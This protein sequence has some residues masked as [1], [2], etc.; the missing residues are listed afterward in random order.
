[1][2]NLEET[3][4]LTEFYVAQRNL[5]IRIIGYSV[6][7][8]LFVEILRA[9]VPEIDLLQLI[10]G[11][12]LL[13]VFI[14]S[15]LLVSVSN[16]FFHIPILLDTKKDIGTKT[17]GKLELTAIVKFAFV[18]LA[19]LLFAVVS[20]ILPLSLDSFENYGEGNL[21]SLWSFEEVLNLEV[22]LTMTV[23]SLSQIPNLTVFVL[24]TEKDIQVL[25]AYWKNF[26]FLV[27]LISGII[28][29]TIDGYTQLSFS[30]SA[31]SLYLFSLSIAVKRINQK[32]LGSL[33][34]NF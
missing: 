5:F 2:L 21:E 33:A 11:F 14:S 17:V 1:M 29:P 32:F 4:D 19:I 20:L 16:S 10:P 27:F 13:L 12:Y 28:T 15:I 34:L 3:L 6:G 23:F 18:L 31:L 9:Q 8:V 26:S 22:I 30:F 24:T 7:V 25:P